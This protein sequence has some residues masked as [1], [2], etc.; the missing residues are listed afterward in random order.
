MPVAHLETVFPDILPSKALANFGVLMAILYSKLMQFVFFGQLR[1]ME[2]EV[3]I[4]LLPFDV[5]Y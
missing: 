1:T 5:S 2:V 3:S 4:T